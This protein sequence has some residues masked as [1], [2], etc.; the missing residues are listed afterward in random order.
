MTD[1]FNS[2]LILLV[3]VFWIFIIRKFILNRYAP[4]KTVKAKVADKYKKDVA[5]K[6][7][8]TFRQE[9]YIVV[10]DTKDKKLSFYVSEFSYNN[11][12][13]NQKGTLKYKGMKIISFH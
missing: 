5:S 7:Y 1:I 4:V 6:Y 12:K 3:V 9:R 13:V 10:F 8:G 11:Y 2:I